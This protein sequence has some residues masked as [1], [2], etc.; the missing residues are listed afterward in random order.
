MAHGDAGN[1]Y[2][3]VGD[4]FLITSGANYTVSSSVKSAPY[5]LYRPSS[6]V[7]SE[8]ELQGRY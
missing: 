6:S 7:A 5:I 8:V 1:G 3:S 4:F 2:L